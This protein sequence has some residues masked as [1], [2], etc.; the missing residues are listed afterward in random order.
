MAIHQGT[1]FFL[2]ALW[3]GEILSAQSASQRIENLPEMIS[4]AEKG[5]FF[6]RVLNAQGQPVSMGTGFLTDTNGS[7]LTALH[8]LRPPAFYGRRA[9]TIEA[10]DASGLSFPVKGVKAEDESLDIVLL[11]LGE[12]PK[13]GLPLTVRIPLCIYGW[14]RERSEQDNRATSPLL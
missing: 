11:P 6:I 2:T 5:V 8:V 10:L 3:P 14:D 12:I 7:L 9:T 4:T 13:N 1:I